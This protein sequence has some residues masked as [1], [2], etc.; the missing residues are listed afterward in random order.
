MPNGS[1]ARVIVQRRTPRLAARNIGLVATGMVAWL[2]VMAITLSAIAL[3][4]NPQWALKLNPFNDAAR[5]VGASADVY[6]TGDAKRIASAARESRIALQGEP[7]LA[8]AYRMIAL[9]AQQRGASAAPA[10][11]A[12]TW[13]T[14]RDYVANLSLIE[15]AVK[16]GDYR[17]AMATVDAS[18]RTS[19]K[20]QELL[21]PV[22][23]K[24][25][26]EPDM[27]PHFV[28][29]FRANPS[30]L[31]SFLSFY[32]GTQQPAAPLA[33]IMLPVR[34][35]LPAS[36]L[37]TDRGL[38]AL[39][40]AQQD[41]DAARAY[42]DAIDT[43]SGSGN[44]ATIRNSRFRAEGK[45]PPIDWHLSRE[46]AYGADIERIEGGNRLTVMSDEQNSRTVARQLIQLSPGTYTLTATGRIVEG[47]DEAEAIWRLSCAE[48]SGS[49]EFGKLRFVR[50]GKP[51]AVRFAVPAGG[52][53]NFYLTLSVAAGFGSSALLAQFSQ[54]DVEPSSGNS[55][56]QPAPP[57]S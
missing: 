52:C 41:F 37:A 26:A 19:P 44:R 48:K 10:I 40:V 16:R 5:A 47:N 55:P 6:G 14:R 33:R 51:D 31:P 56:T 22:L 9:D 49:G 8:R 29:T 15:Q 24:A 39:M 20:G 1:G 45:F 13:L 28:R 54:V 46:G 57:K 2:W 35:A 43:G 18:L 30:W 25:L 38:V 4:Y 34:S 7:T 3:P 12:A 42:V 50:D 27:A 36:H 17:T 11:A 23:G 32:I 21:F 53:R